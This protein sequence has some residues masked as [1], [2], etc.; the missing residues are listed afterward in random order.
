MYLTAFSRPPTEPELTQA[1]GFLE[2]QKRRYSAEGE[3]KAWSDLAHVLYNLKEFIF[4][5]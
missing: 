4:V 2:D 1:L 5:N 3:T